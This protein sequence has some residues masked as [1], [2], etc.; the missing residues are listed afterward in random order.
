MT[1]LPLLVAPDDTGS[2]ERV[3]GLDPVATLQAF[4]VYPETL[5]TFFRCCVSWVR[6]SLS[7]QMVAHRWANVPMTLVLLRLV[8]AELEVLVHVGRLAIDRKCQ[9]VLSPRDLSAQ[10]C[11]PSIFFFLSRESNGRVYRI[12]VGCKIV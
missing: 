11:Q 2:E 12:D 3:L 8:A 10:N 9:I 1:T 4:L 5:S 6:N 7:L